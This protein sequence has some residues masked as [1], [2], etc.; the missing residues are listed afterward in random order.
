MLRYA[1]K[2]WGSHARTLLA[3]LLRERMQASGLSDNELGLLGE[4]TPITAEDRQL[5][6]QIASNP[7]YTADLRSAALEALG[8]SADVESDLLADWVTLIEDEQVDIA[9]RSAALESMS[10]LGSRAMEAQGRLLA[11]WPRIQDEAML[12]SVARTLVAISPT[13]APASSVILQRLKETSADSPL[14][15]DLVDACRSMGPA[16]AA[17]QT[18]FIRGLTH[19]DAYTRSKCIEALNQ[20]GSCDDHVIHALIERVTDNAEDMAVKNAAA[21]TLASFGAPA[22]HALIKWLAAAERAQDQPRMA[23][24]LRTI[25][26]TGGTSQT[27][28]TQCLTILTDP[29]TRIRYV[30]CGRHRAGCDSSGL[31]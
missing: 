1:V 11:L 2:R 12:G 6:M 22:Q 20:L 31:T 8:R 13:S 26:I 19:S 16:A 9:L 10:A 29:G 25:A 17:F 28:G 4:M 5:L 21:E 23:D 3:E 30:S 24:L 14:Y 18:E 7:A 15:V 27:L